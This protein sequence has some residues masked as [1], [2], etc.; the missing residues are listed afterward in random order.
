MTSTLH[1]TPE[2]PRM[3]SRLLEIYRSTPYL[4]VKHSSYFSAYERLFT[5]YVGKPITFVEIGILNGGSLFM[6]REFFGSNARIIGV[7]LN[8]AAKKWQ[9][10]GFEIFIGD[11]ADSTFWDTFFSQVGPVDILLDDGGHTNVQ[12]IVTLSKALPNIRDGG[13]IVIEDTHASYFTDFGNPYKYSFIEFAKRV[14][15]QINSRAFGVSPALKNL[16]AAIASVAFFDSIV[17]FYID[18]KLCISSTPTSNDGISSNAEDFRYDKSWL[19][20]LVSTLDDQ[21]RNMP[22]LWRLRAYLPRLLWLKGRLESWRIR[23][24][25]R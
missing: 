5:F 18:R 22:L 3:E 19:A 17:A 14:V 25:F 24:L 15:D 13:L 12:Q 20:S 9:E 11:Q 1:K 23:A 6:W 7:D 21:L 4:S 8:P 16:D 2:P 10:H